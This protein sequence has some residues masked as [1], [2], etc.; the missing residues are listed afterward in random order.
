MDI[1]VNYSTLKKH[2]SLQVLICWNSKYKVPHGRLLVFGLCVNVL[3]RERGRNARLVEDEFKMV[4]HRL[5]FLP[6][7]L[8]R[9][10]A[11]W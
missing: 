6:S 8:K 2:T 10:C 11:H 1:L 3:W 4:E 5:S 7:I 9:T